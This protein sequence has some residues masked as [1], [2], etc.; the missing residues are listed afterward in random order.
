LAASFC[1]FSLHDE[2]G[3]EDRTGPKTRKADEKKRAARSRTVLLVIQPG[4]LMLGKT[5]IIPGP[6]GWADED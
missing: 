4:A 3:K 6:G 2:H 1:L 5:G